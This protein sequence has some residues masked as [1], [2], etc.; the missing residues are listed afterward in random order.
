MERRKAHI[1]GA[2]VT[3]LVA[4]WKLAERGWDVSIYEREAVIGGMARSWRWDGFI[5]DVGPHIYHSPDPEMVALWQREFG[6]LF[7]TGDFFCA[8]VKGARYNEYYH[9]PLSYEALSREFAPELRTRIVDELARTSEAERRSAKNFKEYVRGLVGPTLQDLFFEHYPRKVWGLSTE[10]MTANW[11]PKRIEIRQKITDFYHGQWNAVGKFGTGCVLESVRDRLLAL[12]GRIELNRGVKKVETSEHRITSL[13]FDSGS[14]FPVGQKDVVI[15]TLP[16]NVMCRL[17]GGRSELAFRG[18]VSVYVAVDRPSILPAG[19]CWLYYDAPEIIFNRVTESKTM[20]PEVAPA[21]RSFVV[22][23]IAYSRGDDL[24]RQNDGAIIAR[25]VDDLRRVGL[26]RPGETVKTSINR[27]P[28]V[29]PILTKD[30]QHEL[31]RAREVIGRYDQL[32]SI[33]TT[34]EF[35]YADIQILFRKALDLVDLLTDAKANLVAA[36]R[37]PRVD[38]LAREVVIAGRKVGTEHRPFIIA[39]AG[40]NHNGSVDLGLKLVDEAAAAGCDAIKFQ[41]YRAADRVSSRVMGAHYAE[42]ITGLEEN[43]FQTLSRLEL[44]PE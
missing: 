39:E 31:A 34:G 26:L 30:Y 10:E 5:L 29:Y 28:N 35:N 3:G 44:D 40:I 17:L 33:G 32:H 19:Y 24:D 16:I 36:I 22:A 13:G 15:S 8:N 7:V 27:Q 41:T 42:Q 4:G 11:A 14:A 23:E 25:V 12:G 38:R 1:L 2:G 43:L 21:D 6:D 37:R 9:Y 18:I 20:A